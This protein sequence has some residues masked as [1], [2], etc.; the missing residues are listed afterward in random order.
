MPSSVSVWAQRNVGD[1]HADVAYLRLEFERT[2]AT[3]FVHVSW[4]DP[5]KVRRVTVAG[6]AKMAVYNDM[7][8]ERVRV[9]DVGVNPTE[10]GPRGARH[11]M[12]V[13]YRSGDIVSP[14]IPFSEPL[15]VQNE[16][17]IDCIRTG[18][19]P[20]TPGERGLDIVRV[21]AATDAAAAS[22]SAAPVDGPAARLLGSGELPFDLEVAS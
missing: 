16:H 10:Q 5:R 21:L 14:Y 1:T 19:R 11:A 4:L 12:P 7:S 8:D 9:Y 20:S 22:G 6:E 13:T 18:R 17:F 3:A 2:R 15:L